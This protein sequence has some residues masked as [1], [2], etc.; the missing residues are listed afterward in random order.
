MRAFVAFDL[1]EDIKKEI[2]QYT[3]AFRGAFKHVRWVDS[4]NLHLTMKFLGEI[5][6]EKAL[7]IKDRLRD[8]VCDFSPFLIKVEGVGCFPN[9]KFPRVIWVKAVSDELF[10]FFESLSGFFEGFGFP[11]ERDFKP[12]ITI[13][14]IK[15]RV[16][17]SSFFDKIG[18]RRE[19]FGDF[20]ADRLTFF[21]STLRKEGALYTKIEEFLFGR[22]I[23]GK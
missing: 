4:K 21:K 23:Y 11:K 20:W 17:L 5:D 19:G 7:A 8:F 13:A 9:F 2:S 12:H 14:R 18:S 15:R 10:P 1:P 22:E 6:E 3:E 16:D